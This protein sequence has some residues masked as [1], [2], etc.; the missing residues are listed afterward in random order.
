MLFLGMSSAGKFFCL[1][2]NDNLGLLISFECAVSVQKLIHV[3][4]TTRTR[5]IKNATKKYK[6]EMLSPVLS[7]DY[8]CISH[9]LGI[10][11]PC[12]YLYG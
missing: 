7:A 10:L 12:L 4:G 9:L 3:E 5:H 11:G 1:I 8:A 2:D 6:Y